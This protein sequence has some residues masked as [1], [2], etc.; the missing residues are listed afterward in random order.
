MVLPT[1]F[2]LRHEH[3]LRSINKYLMIQKK[4]IL[5]EIEHGPAEGSMTVGT[6]HTGAA[7]SKEE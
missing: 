5:S 6:G 2:S 3:D 7:Q 4:A 1:V